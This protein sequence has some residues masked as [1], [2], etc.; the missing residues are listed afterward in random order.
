MKKMLSY[1]TCILPPPYQVLYDDSCPVAYLQQKERPL[2]LLLPF[3]LPEA[4][5]K[6][7]VKVLSPSVLVL[8]AELK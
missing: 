8:E 7:S 4:S 2:G 3:Q 5:E 1:K 6:I